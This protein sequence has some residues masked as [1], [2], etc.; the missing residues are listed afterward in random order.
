MTITVKPMV[1]PTFTQVA[2]ICAGAILSALPTISNNGITGTWS[3][4]LD[5]TA[6]TT[7]TFTP[8]ANQCANTT[9][10][11]ITVNPMV[12][13][14][15]TQVA[16]ICSGSTLSA[17]PTTSN[18]GITGTWSPALDNITTTTYTF[19]PDA[20]QCALSTTMTITVT[21]NV[22]PEFD[23]VAAICSGSTL[24]ALPTTSNNGITGTWSPAL[25]NT[26]TTTYTF[27]PGAGQCA[28]S[29]TM[30]ITVTPNVTPEFNAVA[31]ICAGATLSAL[32]TTS[33]NGIT[34]TWSPALDNTATTTYTFTPDTGQCALSTTMTITV[35]PNVT[36]EF[37][38]V[39]AICSGATL[40]ALPTTSNN[41]ITGTWS[42]ALDNTATTTY[43]FTPDA[44]QCA[45][46][47]TMTITVT[48][49][50]TPEFDAV[51]A[52]C[53]GATLSALP[54]TSNNG[55]TGTWSPALDNTAT[56]T[57]TFTPDAGQCAL[58]AALT[59]IVNPLPAV[60]T[61]T[62]ITVCVSYTLPALA[63]G[64]Y[65]T[66]PD[67]QG[68]QLFA[69]DAITSSQ[70]VYIFADNGDC[71][72][73][74]SFDV[75]ITSTAFIDDLAD[76]LACGSYTLPVLTSV[77]NY[78]TEP[79]GAGTMLHAGDV[80]TTSQTVYLYVEGAISTCTAES[81]FVVTINPI[82]TVESVAD[83]TACDAYMLPTLANGNYFTSSN[84]AG[85]MLNAGDIIT[86]SQT[87]YIYATNGDCSDESSFNVTITP[88]PVVADM[89]DLTTCG[90]YMLPPL[91]TGNYYTA[92]NGGGDMLNGGDVITSSQTIYIY[93]S[94]GDCT[95]ED[96]FTVT[97]MPIPVV[98]NVSDV[99]SCGSYLLPALVTG[100][101]Y[102][103]ANGA[104]TMLMAG[105]AITETQ[106][107]FVYASNG[108]CSTED[109]FTVTISTVD[110]TVSQDGA[111]LTANQSGATYQWVSCDELPGIIP[112]ETGQT[113]TATA[114]G[115][116][117]VIVTLG[118]CSATSACITVDSLGI[119]QP[120]A[121]NVI[122]M[123]PNPTNGAVTI[124]TGH[125]MPDHMM[126]IDN[127]GRLIDEFKPTALQSVLHLD[128]HEDGVYYVKIRFGT[129]E[130]TKKLVLRKN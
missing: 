97:V 27:T 109:N 115:Q 15:F 43:T 128:G 26:A 36:P 100:N 83:V 61:M 95:A 12:T 110:N 33:N 112:G 118:D 63:N 18:N 119:D 104:G 54:T 34:G 21:P 58:S 66:E 22:T 75:T 77:A 106:V 93:A 117:A 16:A 73:Q 14:T 72:A 39:A 37:D 120:G 70:T 79:G 29:T 10:M 99:S 57:Y 40:S 64:N 76:V 20:G 46:S 24:S 45:L 85:V 13:P 98:D 59:I 107:V 56:T 31:A 17:L 116:Y 102:T 87:I 89:P 114:N 103:E 25:N 101:Y 123:Y 4:A 5:N 35:T 7:Y 127:L 86:A 44:D 88:T 74:T 121:T 129:E 84:G 67:G 113:F 53:S 81:D 65:Y 78:Y 28:L 60:S 41:G 32:P 42:P 96:N 71:T 124:D 92:T 3:P 6:T 23:A 9:T 62:D 126:V 90:S 50:V 2:A 38:A 82:P 68:T 55:V 94:N 105:D 69:G 122:A 111:I 130:I 51:A 125:R 1:T 8:G 19:T 108:V 30:T 48:P 49:N 52:I 11:T 47:T 80:I 91:T